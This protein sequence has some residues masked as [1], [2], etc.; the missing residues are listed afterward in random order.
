MRLTPQSFEILDVPIHDV[1]KAE[2]VDLIAEMG[3]SGNG[4]KVFF[5]N[6][7][8]VNVAKRDKVYHALLRHADLVLPDGIGIRLAAAFMGFRVRDNVNGTDLFP[9]LLERLAKLGARIFL[10]GAL[11][12]LAEKVAAWAEQNFPGIRVVGT[13][14]GYFGPEEEEDIVARI[15]SAKAHVLFVAMGVP[16]QEKFIAKHIERAGVGVALGV[17]GLF[18]FYSGRIPRAP[19]WMRQVGL[20]WFYRLLQEP[21]RLWKRYLIGNTLFMAR[22]AWAGIRRLVR[23]LSGRRSGPR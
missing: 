5:A 3:T 16:L 2:A 10:L 4:C 19:L 22:A 17:G 21:R 1:N 6:A 20:E 11:P 12:G 14:H 9:M 13:H 15:A 7:H 18:D 23:S 8:C